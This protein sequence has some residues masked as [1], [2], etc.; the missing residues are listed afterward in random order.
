MARFAKYV[1]ILRV[2]LLLASVGF[3]LSRSRRRI[4]RIDRS[5]GLRAFGN[6]E[7][8]KTDSEN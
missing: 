7:A 4:L 2:D 6:L 8:A 5:R 3:F 1:H